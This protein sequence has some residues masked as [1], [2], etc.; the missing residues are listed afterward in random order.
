[1]RFSGLRRD[2]DEDIPIL[3]YFLARKSRNKDFGWDLSVK[4]LITKA[5]SL[6]L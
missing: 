2:S 1:M 6:E 3:E 5:A 4:L